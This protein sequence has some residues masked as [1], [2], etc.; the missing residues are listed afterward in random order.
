MKKIFKIAIL[1]MVA[2]VQAKNIYWAA[3][4]DKNGEAT[5]LHF[6]D[7]KSNICPVGPWHLAMIEGWND[8]LL[9]WILAG[10]DALA[11]LNTSTGTITY[12]RQFGM[13]EDADHDVGRLNMEWVEAMK[14]RNQKMIE[15]YKQNGMK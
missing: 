2:T 14:Q 15:I 12:V 11:V 3:I 8:K 13:A 10:G 1:L 5:T 4:T 6:T 7:E 9:C